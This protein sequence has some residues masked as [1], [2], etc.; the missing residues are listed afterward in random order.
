MSRI[1][2]LAIFFVCCHAAVGQEKFYTKSGK[3]SFFSTTSMEDIEAINKAVSALLDAQSGELRFSVLMKGFEFKK[4]LMQ[5]HFNKDYVESDKF[6]KSEFKGQ[7]VNNS[8]VNYSQNGSYPVT[9]IGSLSLHGV[10]KEVQATGKLIVKDGKLT[11]SAVF[12]VL[13]A[14][15]NI[16]IPRIHRNNIAKNIRITVDCQLELLV[17][18]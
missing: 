16:T 9:V 14:D 18:S 4:A 12:E 13:V 2:S 10:T 6:P 5:E 3:I 1:I 15:Y 8:S 7:I 17:S 11:A